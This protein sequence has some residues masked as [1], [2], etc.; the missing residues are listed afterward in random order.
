MNHDKVMFYNVERL[1]LNQFELDE[2]EFNGI[3]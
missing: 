3:V 1:R 2:Y